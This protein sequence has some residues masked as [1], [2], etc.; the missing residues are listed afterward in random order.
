[1]GRDSYSAHGRAG[2]WLGAH[3]ERVAWTLVAVAVLAL[4]G[5][6]ATAGVLL[7]R[8]AALERQERRT[9]ALAN[10]VFELHGAA[11]SARGEARAEVQAA[12]ALVRRQNPREAAVIGPVYAAFVRAPF[13]AGPLTR[14]QTALEL[15]TDRE[16]RRSRNVTPTARLALI[17]AVASAATLVGLLAWLFFLERRSGRIDRDNARRAAE[18]VRMRDEFVAS[19]SHELRTPLTSI[20]G[21]LELIMDGEAGDA[22]MLTI[23]QRNAERLL[24]VVSDLLLVA[25]VDGST[26]GLDVRQIDLSS[27]ARFSFDAARP[28]GEAKG[29]RL[30]LE[31][32]APV[33]VEGDAVRLA[34]MMDNLVSNAVKFTQPGGEI[35]VSARRRDGAAV[36]EVRDTGAGIA[37]DDQQQLFTRFFRSR[38][39]AEQ[40]VQGTGL[41]LTITKAIVDAHGGSIAVASNLGVGTTFRIELPLTQAARAAAVA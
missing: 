1:M 29:L 14:L 25:E 27:L 15:E 8:A 32:D 9:E 7:H 17:S 21:Y 31:A 16:G 37:P 34:Q 11:A 23:V 33:V 18:L 3:R 26:L 30:T 36:F 24:R 6:A 2:E 35:M 10:A 5:T 28:A 4:V 41:G 40:A 12:F 13:Q 20:L 38:T 19:V 39:A 22:A